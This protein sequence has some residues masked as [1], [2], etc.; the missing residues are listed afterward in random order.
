MVKMSPTGRSYVLLAQR[1]RPFSASTNRTFTRTR[2]PVLSTLPS[3]SAPTPILSR[4]SRGSISFPLKAKTEPCEMTF[5][6]SILDRVLIKFSVRPSLK[7]SVSGSLERFL[8]GRT[9][10]ERICAG[11]VSTGTR[12]WRDVMITAAPIEP[13]RKR[14]AKTATVECRFRI[15]RS[16]SVGEGARLGAG[17]LSSAG[18]S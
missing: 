16:L 4:T 5:K 3:N 8:S 12:R 15:A 7:Y 2:S 14:R 9:A 11:C 10:T 17:N 13:A 6:P 18:S 1:T